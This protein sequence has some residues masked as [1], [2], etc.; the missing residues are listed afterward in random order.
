MYPP[1]ERCIVGIDQNI[2]FTRIDSAIRGNTFQWN[3]NRNLNIF[4]QENAFQN[5]VW[6]MS[7]MLSRLNGI[8]AVGNEIVRD[9]KTC[10]IVPLL[11]QISTTDWLSLRSDILVND[12]HRNVINIS[13]FLLLLFFC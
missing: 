10:V 2:V 12:W 13:V 8:M 4:I 7:A 6:E 9:D 3:L 1:S 11:H 5:V